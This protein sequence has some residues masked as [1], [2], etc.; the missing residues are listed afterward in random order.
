MLG[1]QRGRPPAP[2]A[3]GQVA[4]GSAEWCGLP[5]LTVQRRLCLHCREFTPSFCPNCRLSSALCGTGKGTNSKGIRPAQAL[6]QRPCHFPAWAWAAFL[7][8]GSQ[9]WLQGP[10]EAHSW[11]G[12]RLGGVRGLFSSP[13]PGP[14]LGQ[15]ARSW[16]LASAEV[17]SQQQ[18]RQGRGGRPVFLKAGF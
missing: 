15:H 17:L 16:A 12:F 8:P 10:L 9:H 11:G 7:S 6:G 13:S 3:Y 4:G 5:P 1:T 14:H 18:V 2:G